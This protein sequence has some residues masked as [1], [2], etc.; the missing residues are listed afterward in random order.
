MMSA[1]LATMFQYRGEVLL[2]ALW[3]VVFPLVS[4][5]M[6]AAAG[7]KNPLPGFAGMGDIAAYFL[8][9][10][11]LGHLTASWDVF[12]MGYLVRTGAMS[13]K[14]LRPLLPIWSSVCDNA[15]YKIVTLIVLLPIW[16]G[17]A[18]FVRPAFSTR[19]MDLL[20]GVPAVLMAMALAYLWGYIFALLAFVMTRIDAAA[21]MYFGLTMFLGGRF[22]PMGFLP[23]ALSVV[24]WFFP[25]RWMLAFPVE[26]LMGRHTPMESLGGLACQA[27][28]LGFAV[29]VFR[30]AW[31]ASV[32]RYSAVGA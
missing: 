3:G 4:L 30:R 15:A 29:I 32:Q 13:P 14:L 6:W 7:A 28:W 21:E 8:L 31:R 27:A 20:L 11:I 16:I 12:E 2:W 9:T 26:L 19:P 17:V 23:P 5:K 22:A 1:S 18:W 24:S 10:M 25:F